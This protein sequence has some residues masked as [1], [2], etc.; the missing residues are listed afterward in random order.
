MNCPICYNKVTKKKK[1][2]WCDSCKDYYSKEALIVSDSYP[3][4]LDDMV[5]IN[6]VRQGSC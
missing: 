2:Y 6:L 5:D 1:A 4:N 3:E